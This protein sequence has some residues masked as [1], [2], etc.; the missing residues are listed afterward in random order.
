MTYQVQELA[1]ARRDKEFIV[2]WLSARSPR[3]V[4][5]WLKAYD[6]AIGFLQTNAVSFGL[7]TESKDLEVELRQIHFWTPKGDPYRIIYFVEGD[8]VFV[9]RIRGPGQAPLQ[10]EDLPPL[11]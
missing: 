8:H 7:A 4:K 3:G 2:E 1:R 9:A 10:P 6:K 5:A 11:P